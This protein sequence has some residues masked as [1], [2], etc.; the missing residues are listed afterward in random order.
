MK[1]YAFELHYT[2]D[3]CRSVLK[4]NNK[5]RL[6]SDI[7]SKPKVSEWALYTNGSGFNSTAQEEYL[8]TWFDSGRNYFSNR[9]VNEPKILAKKYKKVCNLID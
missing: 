6:I 8:I 7:L 1:H 5:H 4:G 3:N 2:A 9:S